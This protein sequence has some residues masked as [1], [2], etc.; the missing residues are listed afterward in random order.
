VSS[1]GVTH[2]FVWGRGTLTVGDGPKTGGVKGSKI[3][4]QSFNYFVRLNS[5][6]TS[7]STRLRTID[8]KR[9]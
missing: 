6:L 9:D 8:E 4:L 3:S 2:C 5:R 7:I 1:Q